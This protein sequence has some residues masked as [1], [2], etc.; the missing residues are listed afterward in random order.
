MAGLIFCKKLTFFC[1]I[2]KL[3]YICI[4]KQNTKTMKQAIRTSGIVKQSEKAICLSCFVTWS[5]AKN[6]VKDI[7]F[8]KSVCEIINEHV[9]EVEEW[10]LDKLGWQHEFHGYT[11]SFDKLYFTP[12]A[13]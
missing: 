5:H 1:K 12:K 11:M 8:P 2:K 3:C 4:R 10:F 6:F 9:V 13:A 7:W